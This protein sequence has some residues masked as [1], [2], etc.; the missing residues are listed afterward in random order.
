MMMCQDC[1]TANPEGMRFCG[2]CGKSLLPVTVEPSGAKNRQCV[3]CGRTIGWDAN[4]CMYCGHDYR[5]RAKPGTEGYLM[6]GG[7]LT[8]LAGVL[9]FALLTLIVTQDHYMSD[10]GIAL[11]A[12]S[13]GCA[14]M[15]I[16]G[17]YAALT[18]RWFPVAVLGAACAIFTPTFFFAIVG[19]ALVARS[20]AS[21]RDYEHKP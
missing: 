18:R 21:F 6:T 16:I 20:A 5:S 11:A 17:G 4:A 14:I 7:V 3:E 10:S 15:G 1:G 2:N 19:L 12:I 13:Y 8:V 9:G